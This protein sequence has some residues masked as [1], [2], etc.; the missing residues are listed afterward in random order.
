MAQWSR[1]LEHRGSLS[2]CSAAAVFSGAL[3]G[4]S[5]SLQ[6]P[7]HICLC[8]EVHHWNPDGL[9]CS[10]SALRECCQ[11]GRACSRPFAP[12]SAL[13][14]APLRVKCQVQAAVWSKSALLLDYQMLLHSTSKL[15][16]AI[17]CLQQVAGL[18]SHG[19]LT[20]QN[21]QGELL[22]HLTGSGRALTGLITPITSAPTNIAFKLWLWQ[23]WRPLTVREYAKESGLFQHFFLLCFTG[24]M[25]CH[26]S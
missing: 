26:S 23:G 7:W 8:P 24:L 1:S 13:L 16:D 15:R 6:S 10:P 9:H 14:A 18:S 21:H 12:C 4:G 3:A 19:L 17:C 25:H 2:A 22:H 5:R 11:A 20:A